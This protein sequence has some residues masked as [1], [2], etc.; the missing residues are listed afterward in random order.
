M[1][2]IVKTEGLL[3]SGDKTKDLGV[4]TAE[5]NKKMQAF[6]DVSSF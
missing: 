2:Y 5:V 6:I 1:E 3:K 4:S